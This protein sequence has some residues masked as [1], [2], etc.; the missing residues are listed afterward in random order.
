MRIPTTTKKTTTGRVFDFEDRILFWNSI[1]YSLWVKTVRDGRGKLIRKHGKQ[2]P[3]FK[4]SLFWTDR[5]RRNA[6]EGGSNVPKHS[7]HIIEIY[8]LMCIPPSRSSLVSLSTDCILLTVSFK[9][10]AVYR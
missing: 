10:P 7:I 4:E 9:R 8:Y 2:I 3:V 6:W 5:F 1:A